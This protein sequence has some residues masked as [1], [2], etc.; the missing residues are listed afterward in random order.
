MLLVACGGEALAPVPTLPEGCNPVAAEHDC[1]LPFPSD[2][3]LARDPTTATGRR[4]SIREPAVL[5]DASGAAFDPWRLHPADG[6]SPGAQILALLPGV[7]DGGSLPGPYQAAAS[8]AHESPTVLLDVERGARV[9]HLSELDPRADDDARRALLVRPLERLRDGGR[10][11]VALR[12]LRDAAGRLVGTPRV[13]RALRDG[14]HLAGTLAAL[15]ARYEEEI[16]APLAAAGVARA[17]LQLAWDFTVRS[18]ASAA[19]EM[20]AVRDQ[21]VAALAAGPVPVRVTSVCDRCAPGVARRIEAELDAPR[22]VASDEPLAAVHRNAA[23]APARNGTAR[24]PFTVWVPESVLGGDKWPGRLLQYGHGFFGARTE[25]DD[26]VAGW[27]DERGFV[28]IATD[29]WGMSKDDLGPVGNALASRPVSALVFADRV[30]QAMVNQIALAHAARTM[31]W[32]LPELSRDGAPAYD[33]G[34]VY[35]YGNSL[36]A[37]LGGTYAALAPDVDRAVLGVGGASF[38]FIM[39]RARPFLS[40]LVLLSSLV[41]DP[42]DQQK[43]AVLAQ[44]SFDRI[45]PLT[46]APLLAAGDKRALLQIGIGD[47]EVPNLA[48]HLHARA[49]DAVHLAPAPRPIEA[50]PSAGGPLA[51]SAIVEFDFGVDPLPELEANP[52]IDGNDA[53]EGVRKLRA[54]GDQIDAFLRPGGL[55]A[56]TCSGACDPE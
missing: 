10:Y 40:F 1:L 55:V 36:G 17:D 44:T 24:V 53:H 23:G 51:G 46:F 33:P 25:V 9:L 28:V 7:A 20:L 47:A 13:F 56:H 4:I 32:A 30:H 21:A 35:Y 45:D 50:V 2:A 48:A 12:G 43:F 18:R 38:V 16:F 6:F 54:A 3:W 15:A 29:W 42:L 41:P 22:F 19:G 5:R 11:V 27:A 31:L 14:E 52:A 39:F 37:I 26:F 8:L 49:L 34:H